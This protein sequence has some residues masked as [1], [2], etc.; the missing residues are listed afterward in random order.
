MSSLNKGTTLYINHK[1]QSAGQ[2]MKVS[3]HLF[4]KILEDLTH[5]LILLDWLFLDLRGDLTKLTFHAL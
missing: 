5:S 4:N 1:I 2:K 3:V